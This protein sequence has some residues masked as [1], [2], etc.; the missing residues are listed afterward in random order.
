MIKAD[1]SAFGAGPLVI[2]QRFDG[3]TGY[4]LDSLQG[5]RADHRRSAGKHDAPNSFPH[6]FLTYKAIGTTVKL[7]GKEKVGDS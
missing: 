5:D 7:T 6:A 2:D 4:V 1:L 3:T